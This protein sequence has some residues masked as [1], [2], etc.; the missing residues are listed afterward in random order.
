M[1]EIGTIAG[2]VTAVRLKEIS[3]VTAVHMDSRIKSA[4]DDFSYESY[5]FRYES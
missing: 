5:N 3:F 2:S 1:T 4:N